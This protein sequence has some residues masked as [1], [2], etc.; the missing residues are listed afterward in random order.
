MQVSAAN[1]SGFAGP[2]SFSLT[3]TSALPA[4]TC[5]P[6]TGISPPT[7]TDIQLQTAMMLGTVAC[8]N[9]LTGSGC[10][11]VDV[12]RVINAALGGA[13]VTGP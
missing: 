2:D 7:A 10:T 12:Q 13:C 9:S 4:A 6:K 11:V 1:G 3:I 5:S 8:T